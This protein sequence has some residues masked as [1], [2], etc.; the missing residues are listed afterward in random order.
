MNICVYGASSDAIDKRYIEAGELLGE[1][2]AKRGHSL[3]YGGGAHGLMGAVARGMTKGG[4]KIVGVAPSFFEVDGVLYEKC[5]EFIYTETMR[6][7]KQIMEESADAFIMTPGGIGTYEE[8]FEI[9]TLKQLDRHPKAIAILNTLGYF[10][11]LEELMKRTADLN[12]MRH[13]SLELYAI[14]SEPEALL[15]YLEN[16]KAKTYDINETKHIGRV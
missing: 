8:F 6:E 2:M 11:P 12:F 3:V 13:K 9:L 1:E 15:S 16:Y 4:G 10:D 7:R 5:T 14:F